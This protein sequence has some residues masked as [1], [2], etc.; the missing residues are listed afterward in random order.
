MV[1]LR[2]LLPTYGEGG[3]ELSSVLGLNALQRGTSYISAPS[4]TSK[5]EKGVEMRKIGIGRR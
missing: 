4:P 1:N 5:N 2:P 3:R